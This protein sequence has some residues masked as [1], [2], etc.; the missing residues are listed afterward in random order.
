MT[1]FF[2]FRCWSIDFNEV[3]S[4][5]LVSGSDDT[6]VKIWTLNSDH[7]TA[8]LDMKSNVCCV[9]F[10]PKSSY[11]LAVASVDHCVHYYDLRNLKEEILRCKGHRKTV[12]YVK[13][14]SDDEIVSAATDSQLKLWSLKDGSCLQ[15]YMGHV[16]AKNF[17]GLDTDGDYIACGSENNSIYVYYKGLSKALFSYPI[18]THQPA[19]DDSESSYEFVSALCWRKHSNV[20]LAANSLGIIKVLKLV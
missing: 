4:R 15:T 19:D 18:S 5:L 20:I 8:T 7:S 6:R 17:V 1:I 3:D 2:N 11:L 9:K 10:H 16:N 13:F 14:I 12:S